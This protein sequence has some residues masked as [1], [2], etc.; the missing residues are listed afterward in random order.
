MYSY[1]IVPQSNTGDLF[2]DDSWASQMVR[3]DRW[4]LRLME[5]D[6]EVG[7]GIFAG[8]EDGWL[9]AWNE[10]EGWLMTR[11]AGNI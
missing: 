1:T 10:G 11:P 7:G 3:P 4:K 2:V 9:D 8:T 5:G 6:E